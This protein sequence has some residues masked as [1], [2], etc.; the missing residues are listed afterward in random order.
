MEMEGENEIE[1]PILIRIFLLHKG[2][3]RLVPMG[4]NGGREYP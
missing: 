4:T 2:L 3:D 1:T